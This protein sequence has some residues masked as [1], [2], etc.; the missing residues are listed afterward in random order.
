[1]DSKDVYVSVPYR[2]IISNSGLNFYEWMEMLQDSSDRY[3]D[4]I[5]NTADRLGLTPTADA[6]LTWMPSFKVKDEHKYLLAKLK[7]GF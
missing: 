7:H 6:S 1:M 3:N 5:R 4:V 2:V